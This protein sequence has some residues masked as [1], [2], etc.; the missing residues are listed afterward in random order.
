MISTWVNTEEYPFASHT[1][2][3]SAGNLHYVDEGKGEVI[4]FIHGTPVWSFVYRKLIKDLSTSYRC[5]AVDHLGF[6]LSD[7]PQEADYAPKAHAQRLEALIEHLQL[8]HITLVVHDFGGPIGLNYVLKHPENVKR[9]VLFNT[10]MWSLNDY[11]EF[12]RAG[13]IA[14]SW[15]GKW[16][17][18]YFNFSPKVLIKQAFY[19]KSKLSK[20][21]HQQYIQAFPDTQSRTGPTAFARHLLAS[22]EWYNSLWERRQIVQQKPVLILWGVKDPLLSLNLLKRWK[23]TLPDARTIE[24]EAGH[25]VQEEKPEEILEAIYRFLN[26][27]KKAVV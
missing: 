26:E 3:T 11:P 22:S 18:K 21:I 5:I 16:L 24:L 6:G 1:F 20:T 25:F 23:E 14:A 17:Y 12:V 15:F 19:D 8:R 13:K 7:K 27:E 2:E 10:W 4:L 9:V